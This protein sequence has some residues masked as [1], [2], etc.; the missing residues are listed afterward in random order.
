MK[1]DQIT[2]SQNLLKIFFK[3]REGKNYWHFVWRK[4]FKKKHM[5]QTQILLINDMAGYGKVALSAM[6]CALPPCQ[7]AEELRE[8]QDFIRSR[9]GVEYYLGREKG[10]FP[11]PGSPKLADGAAPVKIPDAFGQ[12]KPFPEYC[13]PQGKI[14]PVLLG[15]SKWNRAGTVP[16]GGTG[17]PGTIW[18]LCGISPLVESRKSFEWQEGETSK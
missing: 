12:S 16:G 13:W 6:M 14:H 11:D 18:T 10:I 9:K 8:V 1:T 17:I 5:K 15:I 4:E 7:M 3:P 2:K